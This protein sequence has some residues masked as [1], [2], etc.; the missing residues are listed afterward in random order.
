MSSRPASTDLPRRRAKDS[1]G[2][3]LAL[4]ILPLVMIPLLLMGA[5]AYLRS[6][7]IIQEQV[8]TEMDS[9]SAS[10]LQ[11]LQTWGEEREQPLILASQ[12]A[13]L[14][15]GVSVMLRL[16]PSSH[17]A[18][19]ASD[20]VRNQ[21][22][23]LK[24]RAGQ[25]LFSDLLVA[26]ADGRVLVST[27]RAWEG[28]VLPALS[29]ASIPMQSLQTRPV[30]NDALLAPGNL[31]VVTSTPIT[32]SAGSGAEAV[33]VGVNTGSNLAHLMTLA[34]VFTQEQGYFRVE[35]G[36]TLIAM[37]PDV[38]AR[39]PRYATQLEVQAGINHPIFATTVSDRPGGPEY[40]SL[41]GLP[42][43]GSYVW[44]PGWDVAFVNELP[45]AEI[46][47]GLTSLALFT[48]FLV[49]G[50]A[51][52]TVLLVALATSR[53]LRPLA[54]LTDFAGRMARGDWAYRV[55]EDREDELGLLAS[56]LNR[57]AEELS[58]MYRSLEA[59]V[60]ERTRQVRTAAE[61]ARAA[62]SV[63]N[64]DDLLR[65]AV[66]LIPERFGYY[67]AS[68]FLLDETGQWAVPRA[69][70]GEV[71]AALIARGNK[72]AVGSQSMIGWVTLSNHPRVA[73]DVNRDPLHVKDELLPGTRSE[74][75]IPLQVGG[76][77]LG[78]LDVQSL[79][80]HTFNPEDVAVLQMLA[81]QLSAAI[82][83]ARL[84]QTSALAADRARLI[85]EV[86]ARMSGTLE[87]EKVLED[88]A[89]ALHRALGHP[90]ILVQ[91]VKS[92]RGGG[93]DQNI[94]S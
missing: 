91:P 72:P 30:Y 75:V 34:Q 86:T 28:R 46:Y 67:H 51:L 24:S 45:Q 70:T 57:M 8:R 35:R 77:V 2:R 27:N 78:A 87:A 14:R 31:A 20:L 41:E 89:H 6:R 19:E 50:A 53:L 26:A 33:L 23:G 73:S 74:A 94:N 13:D 56:A 68:I 22:V 21:L 1:L 29:T 44:I 92:G 63:T 17:A 90:E 69:S 55:P 93:T 12:R 58:G 83:N 79:K 88:C 64:L 39:L 5:A 37:R 47:T 61:V 84:A 54:T 85:S 32:T 16:P 25:T 59:R 49:G 3:K 52:F 66:E 11:I 71:G 60:E 62:T 18:V 81:D 48:V 40:N 65:R 76:K 7:T 36:Q 38:V 9:A 4:T 80:P 42:V 43:L 10:Q 82:Q 15:D